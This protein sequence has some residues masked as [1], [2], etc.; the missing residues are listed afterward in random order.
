[1]DDFRTPWV[2]NA[3]SSTSPAS[4]FEASTSPFALASFGALLSLLEVFPSL[5][6]G[7]LFG[8]SLFGGSLFGDSLFGDSLSPFEARS[9]AG[10]VL[11]G[12]GLVLR[13]LGLVLRR[14][15][16]RGLG[17]VRH[18]GRGRFLLRGRLGRRGLRR[19][20]V[21]DGTNGRA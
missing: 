7:S 13:G 16:L 2:K 19:L 10:L 5:F 8:D 9:S 4:L 18:G 12:L 14:L 3:S 6:G 20:D 15:A 1:M 11:R 21:G 17:G